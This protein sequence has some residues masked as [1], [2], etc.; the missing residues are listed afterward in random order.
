MPVSLI[1]RVLVLYETA[2]NEV[3]SN[4]SNG[5]CENTRSTST[6]SHIGTE[7]C[8]GILLLK[9]LHS[10]LSIPNCAEVNI[11]LGERADKIAALNVRIVEAAKL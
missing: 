7:G 1:N 8:G 2:C 4:S 10:L 5:V 9:A 3:K 6:I 11:C